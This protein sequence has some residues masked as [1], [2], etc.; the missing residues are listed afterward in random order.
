MTWVVEIRLTRDDTVPVNLAT[1]D[2]KDLM[3]ENGDFLVIGTG[4]PLTGWVRLERE[5]V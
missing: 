2:G 4:N 5:T 3:T 1:E